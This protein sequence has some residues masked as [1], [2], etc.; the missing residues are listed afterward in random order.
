MLRISQFRRQ[1]RLAA[2]VLSVVTLTVPLV[3]YYSTTASAANA[4]NKIQ[5]TSDGP[6]MFWTGT[7]HRDGR[8]SPDIAECAHVNCDHVQIKVNLPQP[9]WS[10]DGGIEISNRW[11]TGLFDD[12]VGLYVY[13]K[14]ERV[15]KSDALVATA[16]GVEIPFNG[17]SPNGN[18]QVYVAYNSL[19]DSP[20]TTSAQIDYQGVAEVEYHPARDP[21]GLLPDMMLQPSDT[22]TFD[23]PNFSVFEPAPPPGQN[24]FDSEIADGAIRCL[25]EDIKS[26]N[27]GL[28]N[29]D[30]RFQSPAGTTPVDGEQV[31]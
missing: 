30:I 31:P 26:S 15:A 8:H 6:A 19:P 17:T 14:G 11:S 5:L 7:I 3:L 29:L 22:I 23:R 1:R 16:Q 4:N 21:E 28:G 24:C 20:D 9:V 18:Y 10:R 2:I 12:A 27:V 25:R 13:Y